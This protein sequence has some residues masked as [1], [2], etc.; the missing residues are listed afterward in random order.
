[1]TAS[2]RR[3]VFLPS[4][5]RGEVAEG[6]TVLEAARQLG[7]DL[8]S[9][10]GG[11]GICGRCQVVP[12]SSPDIPQ[13]IAALSAPGATESQ[14]R[15]RRPLAED[16][17]LGCAVS[18]LDDV[19][20]DIPPESQIHRQVVRK[21]SEVRDFPI[22]PVIRLHYV[23]TEPASLMDPGA[24]TERVAA[25]LEKEWG[26]GEL[27]FDPAAMAAVQPAL[28]QG[29]WSVTAAVH[30]GRE[31]IAVWPGFHDR[32]LG[33]AFD[34]GSTTLAGH[35][36]DLTSGT[37]LASSGRMNPQIRFGE[38]LMSRVSHLML[39]P[40]EAGTLTASVRSA[41]DSLAGALVD[42]VEA[43][44]HSV[45]DVS[46]VGNPIMHHLLL[47]LDPRPLGEAP[48]PP[49]VRHAL[50]LSASHIDLDVNPGA[51]LYVLPVVAGHVG[52]DTMGAV[53]SEGTHR[54]EALQLLV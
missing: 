38:D 46:V 29:N 7:V 49:A 2:L 15:G 32:L 26:L 10:C 23:E 53:L 40:E 9:V 3:V 6:T 43:D 50:H 45:L 41:L 52:A 20:I 31:V 25:A 33:L 11:R 18:I 48:F 47:G 17:R 22:D 28:R 35:L 24:D 54:G 51:R 4:G 1:M 12:G 19:V 13:S 39:H 30:A 14:Y 36:L 16:H 37:V 42:E 5:R 8:D 44:R 27:R 21:R 34:V